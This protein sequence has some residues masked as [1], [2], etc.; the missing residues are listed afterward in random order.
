MD[1][2]IEHWE[3]IYSKKPAF[4]DVAEK[5]SQY[6]DLR[7]DDRIKDYITASREDFLQI[8]QEVARAINLTVRDAQDVANGCQIIASENESKWRNARRINRMIWFLRVPEPITDSAVRSLLEEM[9]KTNVTRG[10]IFTSSSFSHA[11]REYAESRPLE[12]YDKEQL[13]KALART[14]A[15]D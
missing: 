13:Q 4:L 9:R 10:V 15:T 5:L 3:F 1:K 12:L 7:T 11:G 14:G 8:C 2:A 6:Q